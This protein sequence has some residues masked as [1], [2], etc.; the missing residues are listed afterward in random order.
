M[1]GMLNLQIF[2][3]GQA[4]SDPVHP[5]HAPGASGKGKEVGEEKLR[6]KIKEMYR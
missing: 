2:V 5:G 6:W 1:Y 4:A 3:P